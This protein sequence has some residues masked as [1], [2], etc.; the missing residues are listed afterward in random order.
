MADMVPDG[1]VSKQFTVDLA[2]GKK[3]QIQ[4]LNADGSVDSQLCLDSVPAGKSFDGSVTYYGVL[5]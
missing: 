4:I 2:A 5:S 3:I 1:Q